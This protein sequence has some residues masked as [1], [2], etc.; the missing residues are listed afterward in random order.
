MLTDVE[1]EKRHAEFCAGVKL[2]IERG[3]LWLHESGTHVKFTQAG[4]ELRERS[5]TFPADSSAFLTWS[6]SRFSSRIR[7]LRLAFVPAMNER[8]C[9]RLRI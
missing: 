8:R 1:R 7:A 5:R 9:S 6:R 2:A 4:A 3:W